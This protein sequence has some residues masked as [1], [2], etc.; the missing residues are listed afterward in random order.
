MHGKRLS[1][2]V[3]MLLKFTLASGIRLKAT[4]QSF[5]SLPKRDF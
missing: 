3:N 4:F 5:V 1:V 2:K